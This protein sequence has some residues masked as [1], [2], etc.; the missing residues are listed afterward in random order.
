MD[1]IGT[2]KRACVRFLPG[3]A[4]RRA[5]AWYYRRAMT[6]DLVGLE[7]DLLVV[8]RLV[9]EGDSVADVGANYGI[10]T[11]YLSD[12]VGPNGSVLAFE[13]IPETVALLKYNV[14]KL[15]LSN[16]RVS[17]EAVSDRNG[18]VQMV[19]PF[20]SGGPENYYQARV[21]VAGERPPGSLRELRAT[22][23]DSAVAARPSRLTFIKCDVEGHEGAVFSGAEKL[24]SV[25]RPALLVEVSG[26]PDDAASPAAQLITR[27][28]MRGYG[29]YRRDGQ[30]VVPR[31][32]GDHS[33]NYFFLQ[34]DH[35]NR[36]T[37]NL[38]SVP[39]PGRGLIVR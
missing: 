21:V 13:P 33:V 24:L 38:G 11:K 32:P 9:D 1:L 29:C 30:D 27:L 19:V 20:W 16:V 34:Q 23:L 28:S 5:K 18:H 37:N 2:F 17:D 31:Q 22:T 25:D 4:L 10:Y 15:R 8:A 3:P 35:L 7:P 39:D 12:R 36:L 26:D 6:G 14:R